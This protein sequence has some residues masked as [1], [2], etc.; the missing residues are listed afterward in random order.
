M[1]KQ[2]IEEAKEKKKKQV[3]YEKYNVTWIKM[4]VYHP[5]TIYFC[6]FMEYFFA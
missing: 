1:D 2:S 6:G 3:S 4:C 5:K